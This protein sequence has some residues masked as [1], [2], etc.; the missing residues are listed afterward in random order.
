VATLQLTDVSSKS[1]AWTLI[2]ARRD[3]VVGDTVVAPALEQASVSVASASHDSIP[4]ALSVPRR[5][6][7]G[8]T[9]ANNEPSWIDMHGRISLQ[10]S[11]IQLP[12]AGL[13]SAQPGISFSLNVSMRDLPLKLAAYGTHRQ[14]IDGGL[15][16][17]GHAT[18]P[19]TRVYRLALEY[20]DGSSSFQVGRISPMASP[21]VSTLDGIS[22]TQRFGNWYTGFAGGLEPSLRLGSDAGGT[23]KTVYYLGYRSPGLTSLSSSIAY[24]RSSAHSTL[25][26]ETISLS[27]A[28]N[29]PSSFSFYGLTDLD[30]RQPVA[31]VAPF[32]PIVTSFMMFTTV[33][34][35]PSVSFYL[36]ADGARSVPAVANLGVVP[37]SLMDRSMRSG[38]TSGGSLSVDSWNFALSF[39]P[40]FAAEGFA[41]EYSSTMSLDSYD[42]LTSGWDVRM[43]MN[44]NANIYTDFTSY[45]MQV[46]QMLWIIDLRMRVQLQSSLLKQTDVIQKGSVLGFDWVI[47]FTSST[48]F[49]ATADFW[50]GGSI[51]MDV[52]FIEFS[53]R[54]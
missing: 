17:F 41:K 2:R 32:K 50:R 8:S 47:P 5:L 6:M 22:F 21:T 28:M 30:M 43:F 7:A 37:D 45:G 44:R 9:T 26:R 39:S 10:H 42:F 34:L 19:E 18:N 54:F 13:S 40:R 48:S 38:L 11:A 36:G 25:V 23:T 31:T 20:D 4:S 16:P 1:S 51:S 33:Q 52:F 49:M 27:T 35:L 15:S 24:A 14:R 53:W 3:I 46:R 29:G 12:D